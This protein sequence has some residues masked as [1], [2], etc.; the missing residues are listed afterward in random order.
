MLDAIRAGIYPQPSGSVGTQRVDVRD[1]AE[2]AAISL[3][4]P[5]HSGKTYSLV[6]PRAWTGAKIA[7]MLTGHLGKTVIYTGDDLQSWAAQMRAFLPG[8][9]VRDLEIMFQYFLDDGLLATQSKI[10]ELTALLGH[11]PR[12][13]ENFVREV[14]PVSIQRCLPVIPLPVRPLVL[15]ICQVLDRHRLQSARPASRMTRDHSSPML[16]KESSGR[17]DDDSGAIQLTHF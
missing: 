12:S 2:A 13:Y 6:G 8:W 15:S 1:I 11:S 17:L 5:G 4:Q 9:L 16:R 7:E 3:T 14:L 10:D